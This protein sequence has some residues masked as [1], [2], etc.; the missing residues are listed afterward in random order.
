MKKRIL[1]DGD[2]VLLNWEYAFHVWLDHHGHDPVVMD[3]G[4]F[5]KVAD[6]YGLEDEKVIRLVKNFNES[7]SIG[8][9]PAMRDSVQYVR[10]LHEEHDY[11][12]H[13]ITSVSD[14]PDVKR[15]RTMNLNKLFGE[16][17]IEH[18]EC[19]P[20]GNNKKEYLGKFKDSGLCWIEDNIQNAEDGLALGLQPMLVEHGFNMNYEN[21]SIPLVKDWKEIYGLLT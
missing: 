9:L 4:L 3:S 13:V 20:I 21:P 11:I 19:L 6:Q 2:G 15:L 14:E 18:V 5:Y 12:F 1:V 8:F 10:Q 7:A 17:A 16:D